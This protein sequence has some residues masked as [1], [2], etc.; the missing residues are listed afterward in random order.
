MSR[1]E[2]IIVH[3]LPGQIHE[4]HNIAPS[5]EEGIIDERTIPDHDQII[6]FGQRTN[7]GTIIP[8]NN[9]LQIGESN[10]TIRSSVHPED[11][12]I[13]KRYNDEK[14]IRLKQEKKPLIPKLT[15]E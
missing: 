10:P 1:K 11:T 9:E 14:A 12:G 4:S 7:N 13:L 3:I 5:M 2:D 15:D 6:E 8:I